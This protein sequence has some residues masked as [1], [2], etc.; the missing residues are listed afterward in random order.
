MSYSRLSYFHKNF[1]YSK[2]LIY[3]NNVTFRLNIQIFITH[4]TTI[5]NLF[6]ISFI[7]LVGILHLFLLKTIFTKYTAIIVIKI[8]PNNAIFIIKISD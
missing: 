7:K 1:Y 2:F 3:V 4:D 5:R 6:L 8:L